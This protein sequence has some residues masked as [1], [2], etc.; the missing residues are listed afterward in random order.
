MGNGVNMRTCRR[1]EIPGAEG[2][3]KK[4]GLLVLRKGFSEIYPVI[5]LSKG[6]LAF[7]CNRK[8]NEGDRVVV[9]LQVPDETTMDLKSIVTN[10]RLWTDGESIVTGVKF[11]P[12]GKRSTSNPMEMLDILRA[13]DA[14][15]GKD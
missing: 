8:L 15:Y 2:K 9:Q 11:M 6:G 4:M 14:K 5:N 12:F 7:L 3:Y 1:F 13:L 10:Q